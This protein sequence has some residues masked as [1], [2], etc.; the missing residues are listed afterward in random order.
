MDKSLRLTFLGHPVHHLVCLLLRK[1]RRFFFPTGGQRYVAS[2]RDNYREYAYSSF[3]IHDYTGAIQRVISNVSSTVHCE[4]NGSRYIGKSKQNGTK[5]QIT[6]AKVH[7]FIPSCL[8]ALLRF[9]QSPSPWN[10]LSREYLIKR[11]NRLI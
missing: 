7:A 8:F 9:V 2:M 3:P 11:L 5:V 6:N 1:T 4:L 10:E